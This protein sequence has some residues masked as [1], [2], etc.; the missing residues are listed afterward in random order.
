MGAAFLE[1]ECNSGAKTKVFMTEIP[2]YLY[3]DN[4]SN[5]VAAPPNAPSTTV[6]VPALYIEINPC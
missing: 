1:S 4:G 2:F 5:S 6:T 3:F